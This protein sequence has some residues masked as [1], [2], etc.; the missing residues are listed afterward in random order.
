MKLLENAIAIAVDAHRGQKERNGQPYIMHP[1]RVMQGVQTEEEKIVALLHDLI[2]DTKWTC[3]MLAERG[4]PKHLLDALDCVTNPKGES[5]QAFILRSA[6]TPIARR[7]KLAD[8]EDN[9]DIRRLPQIT[10]EDRKRL[11]QYLRAYRWLNATEELPGT[12]G[13]RTPYEKSNK[14]EPTGSKGRK[15]G[16][17]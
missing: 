7:V 16:R 9:M 15:R 1:L 4:F 11:T 14:Y 5:Y 6:S 10:D 2:E 17:S 8:L 13:A 3:A 12:R